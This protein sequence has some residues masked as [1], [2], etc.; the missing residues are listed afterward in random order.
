VKKKQHKTCVRV[1]QQPVVP[2]DGMVITGD[3]TLA[4][5]QYFLPRGIEI[6]AHNV[7]VNAA[8]V[9]LIGAA[10]TGTGVCI[11]RRNG[12]T[13]RGLNLAYYHTGVRA[14]HCTG[15]T[16]EDLTITA[17]REVPSDTI[18]LDVW[19]TAA[20]SYGGAILLNKVRDSIIAG[21]NLEHNM[22]GLLTYDCARLR[23]THNQANYCSGY[24]FHLFGTCNAVFED[25]AADYCCR[26]NVRNK[27][28]G[29]KRTG[30]MGADATGFLILAGSHRN[31]FRRNYARMG[32]DGF[33]L[34]GMN[35]TRQCGANDNLFEDNDGSL[36]PNI[37]FEATFSSGNIFRNN[38]ANNCNYGFWLGY[39]SG[40]VIEHNR[41]V[42]NRQAGIAV[43]NGSCMTV[44]DNTFQGNGHG[45]LLWSSIFDPARHKKFPKATTSHH[46]EIVKNVF[47]RNTKAIRIARAQDHGIRPLPPEH[48]R[49]ITLRP[50]HHLIAENNIQDNRVGIELSSV[51]QTTIRG[52]IL[53][54]NPEA[55]IRQDDAHD[56]TIVNNLGAAGAYL[57]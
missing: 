29:T 32:G 22:N 10:R 8:G 7:T 16:L 23:V 46:W 44:R 38:L 53:H 43:E 26:Y 19:L 45:I 40:N 2:H 9:L 33:F 51:D 50:H 18:F 11:T 36:S 52:N 5:G 3:V 35:G 21:N 31:V 56:T 54:H 49:L 12:V 4:P 17:T 30:H 14:E 20:T 39:S 1:K 34:A 47:Q 57:A 15:L 42:G 27:E 41:I 13:L 25:N 28:V 48:G 37:A 55:N 6:A 24:G